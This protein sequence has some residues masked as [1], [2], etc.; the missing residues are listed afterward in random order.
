MSGR[1]NYRWPPI[2][3]HLLSLACI[4]CGCTLRDPCP[5]GCAWAAVDEENG[6]A[7]CTACSALPLDDLVA[8]LE[9]AA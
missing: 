7:L 9:I 1:L 5:G 6:A 3:E 8:R 2:E 4:A